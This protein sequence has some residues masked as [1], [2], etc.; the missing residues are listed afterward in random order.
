MITY[1]NAQDLLPVVEFYRNKIEHNVYEI[2]MI[3]VEG[4]RPAPC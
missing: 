2:K 3:K 4:Y 1:T